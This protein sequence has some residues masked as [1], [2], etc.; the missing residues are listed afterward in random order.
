MKLIIFVIS[1]LLAIWRVHEVKQYHAKNNII[2]IKNI[3]KKSFWPENQFSR[4]ISFL[5]IVIWWFPSKKKF[6]EEAFTQ[7]KLYCVFGETKRTL[8]EC[9][10]LQLGQAGNF[11]RYQE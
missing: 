9:E 10:L 3:T 5:V 1:A 6:R 11:E 4:H 8:F 2:Y 7:K